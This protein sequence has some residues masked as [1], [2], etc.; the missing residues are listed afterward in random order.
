M[1][2][3]KIMQWIVYWHTSNSLEEI[4]TDT[5]L[6]EQDPCS[7]IDRINRKSLD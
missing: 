5:K 2:L 1:K 4:I 7:I 6:L 3:I